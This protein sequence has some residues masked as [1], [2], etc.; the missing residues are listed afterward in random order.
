MDDRK[1]LDKSDG[2]EEERGQRM[3][4][5][6]SRKIKLTTQHKKVSGQILIGNSKAERAF[7]R[8][9]E[10]TAKQEEIR[11]ALIQI[12]GRKGWY[13]GTKSMLRI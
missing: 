6:A 9:W 11:G 10:Q 1:K 4:R 13:N 3:K 7:G 2:A 12:K 8:T 5:R